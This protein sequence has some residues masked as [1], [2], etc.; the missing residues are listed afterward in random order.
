MVAVLDVV[1][2]FIAV[3]AAQLG[4]SLGAVSGAIYC[5]V[6]VMAAATMLNG[7]SFLVWLVKGEKREA[8]ALC[9]PH[10]REMDFTGK[11]MKG[12]VFVA[13]AGIESDEALE[14]WITQCE[15]FVSSLPPK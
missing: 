14:K 12:Y 5:V 11:P 1:P 4:L 13:P 3:V 9:R 10:T 8:E 15:K 7:P 6:L 2:P